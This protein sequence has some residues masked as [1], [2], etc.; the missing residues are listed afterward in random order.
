[1]TGRCLC[2]RAWSG[3]QSSPGIHASWRDER[4]RSSLY[5]MSLWFNQL[6]DD[7]R[8]L[9][10]CDVMWWSVGNVCVRC[11]YIHLGSRPIFTKLTGSVLETVMRVVPCFV[12]NI[13]NFQ[14][15]FVDFGWPGPK[16]FRKVVG[17]LPEQL[18]KKLVRCSNTPFPSWARVKSPPPPGWSI[19]AEMPH[20]INLNH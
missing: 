18:C 12:D 6:R 10:W 11:A 16:I 15:N 7:L 17:Q 8:G 19:C 4:K 2:C 1:M 9:W 3:I 13:C 20:C 14:L 5:Q